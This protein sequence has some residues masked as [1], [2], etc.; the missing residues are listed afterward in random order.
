RDDATGI[1]EIRVEGVAAGADYMYLIDG[2]RERPDPISRSQPRGVH[3]QSRVVD[4]HAFQW[5]DQ[6]WHGVPLKDF[7]IY[8]L[9]TGTFTPE[10]TF[11]AIIPQLPYLKS[12][13]V[14]AVEL[15]PVAEFPGGRN[16]GYDG[17][18]LYA[19]QSTYGGPL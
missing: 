16:W 18:Y 2:E 19:P 5:T 8:E 9:H 13:G 4:P 12:L 7:L 1:F 14:T 11:E 6:E 17:T 3:A 15:M 10:G